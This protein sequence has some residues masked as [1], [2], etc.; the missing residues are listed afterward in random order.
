M[1]NDEHGHFLR[2]RGIYCHDRKKQDRTALAEAANNMEISVR[3]APDTIKADVEQDKKN[4]FP[5]ENGIIT[6][7]IQTS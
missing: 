3:R 5:I 1:K 7:H 2:H 6:S 4:L